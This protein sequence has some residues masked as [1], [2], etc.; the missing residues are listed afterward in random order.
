MCTNRQDYELSTIDKQLAKAVSGSEDSVTIYIVDTD[1]IMI[2]ASVAGITAPNGER[3]NAAVS[4]NAIVAASATTIV[5]EHG[6]WSR[7]SGIQTVVDVPD[8]YGLFFAMSTELDESH[9]LTWHVIVAERIGRCD[10]TAF[11]N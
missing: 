10:G 11:Y 4:S 2:S 1:G 9:G 3:I 6:N 7:A 5:M 8:G